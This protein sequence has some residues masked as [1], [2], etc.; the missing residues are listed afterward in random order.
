MK[1]EKLTEDDSG[2]QGDQ[3]DE[4]NYDDSD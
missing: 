3:G 4:E 2:E 1:N